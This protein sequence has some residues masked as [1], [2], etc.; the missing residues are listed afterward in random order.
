VKLPPLSLLVLDTETTGF[1]PGLHRVIEYA[2]TVI[3]DGKIAS[4]YEQLIA[5]ETD[6]IPEYVQVMTHIRPVDLQGKPTFGD[7]FQTMEGMLKPGMILVGQNVK[8]DV[9]MLRGEGW[10]LG[11]IPALDTAMLA[12]LVFPEIKSY[13]LSFVTTILSL[14][15]TPK[16]RAL[17]DVRAT[18]ALLGKCWERLLELPSADRTALAALASRG[19]EGYRRFFETLAALPSKAR[20][21]P[22][23]LSRSKYELP[24]ESTSSPQ[25][26]SPPS[27]GTVQ[28]CEEPIHPAFFSALLNGA[29]AHTWIAVK[30]IDATLRRVSSS[31]GYTVLS[32]PDFFLSV[33][34]A[35]SFLAQP[36]FTAD[37]LTLAMKLYLYE[38]K[39]K[40]ELPIHGEEYQVWSAKLACNAESPEYQKRLASASK[41]MVLLSHHEL[42]SV[43]RSS[44][45]TLPSKGHLIIDDASMLEDTAT[46]ALGWVCALP[47]LR[48]GAQ[49]SDLLTKCVDLIELWV[50]KMRAGTDLKYLTETDLEATEAR[51]VQR[52]IEEILTGDLAPAPR[53]A[54]EDLSKILDA[55][56]LP[57]RL[58]WVES[59]IDGSKSIRSVPEDVAPLLTTLLYDRLPTTLLIPPESTEH[60]Q[61]IIP[62]S[63]KV[64]AI[65][66]V[67][68]APPNVSVSLPLNVTL[69]DVLTAPEG[70]T[71]FLVSSKRVIEGVYIRHS[72]QCETAGITLLCQGFNG[73]QSRMQAEFIALK[74]PAM[75]VMTP[76]MY[77]TLELPRGTLDRL[78]IQTLPFDHPSHAVF[79]KR[80][81][82]YQSPFMDYAFPRL[83][84]RLFRLIRTFCR[85]S[86][87][88]G[89]VEILDERLRTKPYG[90]ELAQY[91]S[92]LLKQEDD[93]QKKR[94]Q[95]PLL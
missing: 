51:Q 5:A 30:N 42:L 72:E 16:H 29:D 84:H 27:V 43:A 59:F 93:M 68:F 70:K 17:G 56:N 34:A 8:F 2:C 38:P 83:R 37:E 66:P 53:R 81:Q 14:D 73:G 74:A 52:I 85:H 87:D 75:L 50:E 71:V 58:V 60:L 54:L 31:D 24:A 61:P 57:G 49:G 76:W 35:S 48:A 15:H 77:E 11:D 36:T 92:S 41:G 47:T 79:S 78:V 4:E 20:K 89:V 1:V 46:Q 23:W 90:K 88:G 44:P 91:L 40:R 10:D 19:P 82:R 25:T 39:N 64:A 12:S 7:V 13:S 28:L 94:E 95:M 86:K 32:S 6:E 33:S 45:D 3:E 55:Q 9:A 80:G 22:D 62:L 26:I 18:T 67:K 69:D 65:P 63:K 21:R